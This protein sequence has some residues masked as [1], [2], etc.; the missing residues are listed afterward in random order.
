[1]LPFANM[2]RDIADARGGAE[3]VP[4]RGGGDAD[5]LTGMDILD[6]VRLCTGGGGEKGGTS[7]FVGVYAAPQLDGVDVRE[8]DPLTRPTGRRAADDSAVDCS[9]RQ[10]DKCGGGKRSAGKRSVLVV[11]VGE[12]WV[13]IC[14][15][16]KLGVLYL[17]S[18]GLPPGLP[19]VQRF[20]ARACREAL[21]LDPRKHTH[22]NGRQVQAWKS[23]YCGLYAV[24]WTLCLT[25]T[26]GDASED[27]HRAVADTKIKFYKQKRRLSENDCLCGDYLRQLGEANSTAI[28]RR[29][30]NEVAAAEAEAKRANNNNRKRRA[31]NN[32]NNK[33]RKTAKRAKTGV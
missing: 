18:Y 6:L 23:N 7:R 13:T 15:D 10:R 27:E 17:D 3:C 26:A 14:L 24:L 33:T 19:P 5:G 20:I 31:A 9:G 30:A 11:N 21:K 2:L 12:H 22:Y 1:M 25:M 28:E 32:N 29:F 16:T 8:L 4:T